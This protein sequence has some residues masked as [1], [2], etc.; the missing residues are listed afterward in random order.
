MESKARIILVTIL[1]Q[2]H[3]CTVYPLIPHAIAFWEFQVSS[4]GK[5]L[6][7]TDSTYGSAKGVYVLD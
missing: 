2:T 5:K 3:P 1:K 6:K 4:D 7:M